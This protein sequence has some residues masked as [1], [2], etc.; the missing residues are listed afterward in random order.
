MML[1]CH[2]QYILSVL[3]NLKSGTL[4]SLCPIFS[5][6]KKGSLGK[7]AHKEKQIKTGNVCGLL[8]MVGW[9]LPCQSA[10]DV[11]HDWRVQQHLER[12]TAIIQRLDIEAQLLY[13]ITT[14]KAI[15]I[16]KKRLGW[17]IKN[18]EC[19]ECPDD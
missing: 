18:N 10:G 4:I 16:C 14:V 3:F 5:T 19:T 1:I 11:C 17:S 8:V 13:N 9:L 7:K 15:E 2:K 6:S 12:T